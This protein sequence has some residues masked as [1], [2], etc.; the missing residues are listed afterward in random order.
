M[1][2]QILTLSI[3]VDDD[4]KLPSEWDWQNLLDLLPNESVEII[5]IQKE[6]E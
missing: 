1:K 6:K 4:Y 5:D 2:T 3:T